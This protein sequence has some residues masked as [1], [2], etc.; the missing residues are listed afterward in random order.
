MK[1]RHS[2]DTPLHTLGGAVRGEARAR[3]R[4]AEGRGG[5]SAP[6]H[7]DD[8]N[9]NSSSKNNN[10]SSKNNNHNNNNKNNNKN[11]KAPM[12]TDDKVQQDKQKYRDIAIWHHCMYLC[13]AAAIARFSQSFTYDTY[14]AY[15]HPASP[16]P[17]SSAYV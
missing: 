17:T 12:L 7:E 2:A 8:E 5:A 16:S 10:S 14:K 11:N 15:I 3:P 13:Y 1:S 6:G 9:T 4:Q